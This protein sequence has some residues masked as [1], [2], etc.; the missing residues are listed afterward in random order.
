MVV[1]SLAEITSRVANKLITAINLYR[2]TFG[3]PVRYFVALL[4]VFGT[5]HKYPPLLLA[6]W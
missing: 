3:S 6:A 1:Y 5:L 4:N 2:G